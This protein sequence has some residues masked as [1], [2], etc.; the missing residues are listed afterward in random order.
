[1]CGAWH[2]AVCEAGHAVV[3]GAGHAVVCGAGH[4]VVTT[5]SWL[6]NRLV[7]PLPCNLGSLSLIHTLMR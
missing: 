6:V 2:A 5:F 7:S 4:S 1:M 3:Y